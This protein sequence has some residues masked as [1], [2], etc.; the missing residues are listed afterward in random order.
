MGCLETSAQER[1]LQ[2][3]MGS[4]GGT[5]VRLAKDRDSPLRG[6]KQLRDDAFVQEKLRLF[7]GMDSL[8]TPCLLTIMCKRSL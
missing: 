5:E 2:V 6:K 3:V 1:F 4:N 8:G 7:C